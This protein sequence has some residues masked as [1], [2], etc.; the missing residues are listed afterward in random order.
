MDKLQKINTKVNLGSKW[1]KMG[2]EMNKQI[3]KYGWGSVGWM[4]WS[5]ESKEKNAIWSCAS[6]KLKHKHP[7][8]TTGSTSLSVTT[9][10]LHPGNQN[11]EFGHCFVKQWWKLDNLEVKNALG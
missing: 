6:V 8:L 5:H 1:K 4:Q 7:V 11:N 9:C 10:I 3:N 2:S